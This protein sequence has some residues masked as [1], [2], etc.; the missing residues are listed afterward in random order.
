[1]K[2]NPI[3][4]DSHNYVDR[5]VSWMYF[6]NRVL[7]E[8]GN[9]A[10]PLYERLNFLGIY[11][12]NLDEFYRV[13]VASLKRLA[14]S[15]GTE[16][17]SEKERAKADLAK[18]L[19]LTSLYDKEYISI[20]KEVFAL[21]GRKNIHLVNERE[22]DEEQQAY[23]KNYYLRK[24]DGYV[25]PVFI[26]KKVAVGD[27]NDSRIYL[28]CKLEKENATKIEYAL[29]PIP[30]DIVG[31]FVVLP[32][33]GKD[34]YVRYLDD[35]LRLN[36]DFIFKGQ[37][38]DH[39]SAFA[40]KLSKD[41]EREVESDPEEGIFRS[42]SEAI[43]TR[44]KGNPV[45]AV[46][47][48]GIPLDLKSKLRKTFDIKPDDLIQVGGRY[49]NNKDL[50]K[51]PY[52][53]NKALKN[54]P[55]ESKEL[56]EVVNGESLLDAVEKKDRLIHVPYQSFDAFVKLLQEAAI[57][58][59]V[60]S[61]K[62]AIYR[63]ANHSK[64]VRALCQA[65]RN[66]KKVTCRVELRARFDESSNRLI[67]KKLRDA[68]VDV[69]TGLEGFKVHGKVVVIKRKKKNDI[70]VVSTGNFHEGN[71]SLYTDCLL[72]T[73]NKKI[74]EDV[75]SIFKF[76]AKPFTQPTF[77][78]LFV[79]PNDR[80]KPFEK[81]IDQEINNA[82]KGLPASICIKINHITDEKRVECLYR[83]SQAGVK[84]KLL[85]RGNC[86]LVPGIKGLSENREIHGI[87]DRYLEHSRIFIFENGGKPLYYRGSAD[88]RP[89]NLYNRV[90]VVTPVYDK[91]CQRRL[92]EIFDLGFADNTKSFLI[93]GKGTNERF[94]KGPNKVESQ[95][96]LY[97]ALSSDKK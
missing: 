23:V 81:L 76:L 87:I 73:A 58:P 39:I 35:V 94:L 25:N 60:V 29:V 10:V 19:S 11:S 31:R 12:N 21:L 63:A 80:Q 96:E 45:R 95:K 48:E 67:S 8:A 88:F 13:R 42:L 78:K 52:F 70:A 68:G 4:L 51:F 47:G 77:H 89:R 34:H 61:I 64:V 74:T 15:K 7:K 32:S 18:I 41:A 55:W 16:F 62:A 1:M 49:H 93:D 65:A 54:V 38:Y 56:S 43:K 20:Q 6:N 82:R 85:V 37:G 92:Q 69:L 5:D 71:A 84:L 26:N 72:F 17:K 97:L 9:K 53:G 79:S 46:F 24:I 14:A 33:K 86:S 30:D 90:E 22:L 27:V 50:R 91:E 28:A 57:A 75:Q 36:L 66:G 3:V 83:A 59:D 40:F 2:K 44:K